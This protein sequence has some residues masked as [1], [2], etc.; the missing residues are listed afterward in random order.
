LAA[1]EPAA[2]DAARADGRRDTAPDPS[3]GE[4]EDSEMEMDDIDKFAAACFV[5][6]PIGFV[7]DPIGRTSNIV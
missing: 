1:T 7:N 5:D 6:D 2:H 4:D 3:A